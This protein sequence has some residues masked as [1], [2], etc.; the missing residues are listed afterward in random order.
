M[1]HDPELWSG[2]ISGALLEE[3][4]VQAFVDAGFYGA[5]LLK[6]DT[7]PWRTVQGIEFRS[8]T[9]EAFKGES[10]E[11]A[12]RNRTVIYKGPFQE[13]VDEQGLRLE[14]GRRQAV[15]D[16]TFQRYGQEPYQDCFEL[17]ESGSSH[18]TA[19][20]RCSGPS[21]C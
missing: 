12:E 6:R 17:I 5:R 13:V 1:Q 4:F 10:N 7:Q 20:P 21:C 14:R 16:Q 15:S 3:D 11:G 2:C 9:I 18:S 19:Q 8:V